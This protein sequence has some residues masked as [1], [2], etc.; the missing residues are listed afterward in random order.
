MKLKNFWV[1]FISIT[2]V[3]I[4]MVHLFLP[5]TPFQWKHF[6]NPT[7]YKWFWYDLGRTITIFVLAVCWLRTILKENRLMKTAVMFLT[8]DAG[9]GVFDQLMFNNQ[10][11]YPIFFV[12]CAVLL[13]AILICVLL[14]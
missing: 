11:S 9:K 5:G 10:Y 13:I 8:I 7:T 4:N 14:F 3:G 12:Q 1:L 6:P 2:L